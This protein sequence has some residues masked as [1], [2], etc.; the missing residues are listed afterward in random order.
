MLN[1]AF[2]SRFCKLFLKDEFRDKQ[3]NLIS[4]YPVQPCPPEEWKNVVFE[5]EV[6]G[7]VG[8]RSDS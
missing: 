3:L 4:R 8:R 6:I 2:D 7:L 5:T 1:D